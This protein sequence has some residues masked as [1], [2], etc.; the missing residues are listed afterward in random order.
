MNSSS[1]NPSPVQAVARILK[2]AG[3]FILTAPFTSAGAIPQKQLAET[4]AVTAISA[5]EIQRREESRANAQREI[6][7]GDQLLGIEQYEGALKCFGTA[8]SL[9]PQTPFA[10]KDRQTA[11]QGFT[12]ASLRLAEQRVSEGYALSRP[13]QPVASAEDIID[14]LL[15]FSPQNKAATRFKNKIRTPGFIN[16]A[17]TPQFRQEIEKVK[18]YLQ[19]GQDFFKAARF[20]LAIKRADQ[21]LA[22]DPYNS[23]ARKLQEEANHAISTVAESGYN[24]SRSRALRDVE[25]AWSNP[26]RRFGNVQLSATERQMLDPSQTEKLRLKVQ[27][28][29][30]PEIQFTDAPISQV[31]DILTKATQA[32]DTSENN[33]GI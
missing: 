25:K 5:K 6:E 8:L 33:G 32:V 20:D 22:L 28:L 17:I 15:L 16:T 4:D 29:V 27:R 19:E 23:A 30:L 1:D 3:L 31:A 24:E 10:A 18:T 9:L 26:V 14:N 13:G 21:V 7:K 2:T 11:L 12:D